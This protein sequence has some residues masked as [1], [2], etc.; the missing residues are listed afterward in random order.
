MG[1]QEEGP[2]KNSALRRFALRGATGLVLFWLTY[3]ILTGQPNFST[4]LFE[5]TT[6]DH[7]LFGLLALA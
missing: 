1:S 6:L 2:L 7:A 3:F 5:R 4:I